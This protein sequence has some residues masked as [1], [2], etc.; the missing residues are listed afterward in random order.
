[1]DDQGIRKLQRELNFRAHRLEGAFLR[2][3]RKRVSEEDRLAGQRR[4]TAT[5]RDGLDKARIAET[6]TFA[7][8]LVAAVL[9]DPGIA[10]QNNLL[11]GRAF[12]LLAS[13][14]YDVELTMERL[15]RLAAKYRAVHDVNIER[16][17]E[18]A[19]D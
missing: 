12:K 3:Q 10:L 17:T 16:R 8:A 14:G 1:M 2:P 4:R 15:K 7:R 11:V 6:D 13:A 5:Y 18:H 19:E 9:T